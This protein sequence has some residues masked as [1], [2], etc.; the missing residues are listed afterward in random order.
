MLVVDNARSSG[1]S[2]QQVLGVTFAPWPRHIITTTG[3]SCSAERLVV[4]SGVMP[5]VGWAP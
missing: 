3:Y 5:P 2:V 1:V 4:V